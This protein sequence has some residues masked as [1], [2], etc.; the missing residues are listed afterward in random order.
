MALRDMLLEAILPRSFEPWQ[1]SGHAG[2][3]RGC[4]GPRAPHASLGWYQP[5]AD[6][7]YGYCRTHTARREFANGPV[8][9]QIIVS[10]PL[11]PFHGQNGPVRVPWLGFVVASAASINV[12]ARTAKP[13]RLSGWQRARSGLP[14]LSGA[15]ARVANAP[16]LRN[17]RALRVYVMHCD[18]T[19]DAEHTL[20]RALLHAPVVH[21][22][23][24]GAH[25]LYSGPLQVS[26]GEAQRNVR[27][28]A[29]SRAGLSCCAGVRYL[30][31]AH[32]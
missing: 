22:S 2:T 20:R 32:F 26:R 28:C 3:G 9:A 31:L 25:S 10:V 21:V 30:A 27:V 11:C 12:S 7:Q 17:G 1:T 23:M 16:Q 8:L 24:A 18:C 19:H 15:W 13:V 5:I 14:A 29:T 6:V 4:A